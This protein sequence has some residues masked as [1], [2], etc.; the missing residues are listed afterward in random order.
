MSLSLSTNVTNGKAGDSIPVWLVEIDY[1]SPT[2]LTTLRYSTLATADFPTA[3][4]GN[5]FTA[6]NLKRGGIGEMRHSVNLLNGGNMADVGSL[7]L[8]L[9]NGGLVSDTIDTY[10]FYNR[11]VE[12][13]LIFADETS[14]TWANACSCFYGYAQAAYWDYDELIIVA[15]GGWKARHK[16]LVRRQMIKAEIPTLPDENEGKYYGLVWGDFFFGGSTGVNRRGIAYSGLSSS[17]YHHRDYIVGHTTR[18]IKDA[19]ASGAGTFGCIAL[20][21]HELKANYN[22]DDIERV[23]KWNSKK[24]CYVTVDINMLPVA[25]I[26][27]DNPDG[28]ENGGETY[29]GPFDRNILHMPV[30]TGYEWLYLIPDYDEIASSSSGISN[31]TYCTDE[32]PSNRTS[33]TANNTDFVL[34]TEP[35]ND[36][37]SWVIDSVKIYLERDGDETVDYTISGGGAASGTISTFGSTVSISLSGATPAGTPVKIALNTNQVGGAYG[38]VYVKHIHVAL[39]RPLLGTSESDLGA[40]IYQQ[41]QGRQF[42]SFIDVAN[43]SNSYSAGDLIQN[44]AYVAESVLCQELELTPAALAKSV[45]FDG[46]NDYLVVKHSEALEL[47]GDFTLIAWVYPDNFTNVSGLIRKTLS[48][49]STV[50]ANFDWYLAASTGLPALSLGNGSAATATNATNPPASTG[51]W[52]HLAVKVSGT[53]VTHYRNGA[54][55]GSATNSATRADLGGDLI[56]GKAAA[57]GSPYLNGRLDE[58]KIYNRALSDAE[59]LAD[60]NSGSGLRG[61]TGEDGLV[62]LWHFD[63]GVGLEFRDS[64]GHDNHGGNVTPYYP[65]WAAGKVESTQQIKESNFDTVGAERTSWKFGRQILSPINSRELLQSIS[66]EGGFGYWTRPDGLESLALI[67]ATGSPSAFTTADVLMN[68]KRSSLKVRRADISVVKTEF[69]LHYRRNAANGDYEKVL[70]VKNSQ[71]SEFDA[72]FTNLASDD[73]TYWQLCADAYGDFQQVARWEYNADW[74]RDDATAELFIKFM[75]RWL[76]RLPLIVQFETTIKHIG[77][78]LF[79]QYK[80]NHP[81][82]PAAENNTNHFIIVDQA[83]RPESNTMSLTLYDVGTP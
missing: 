18:R 40:E 19:V 46:S 73:S 43:H 6:N 82:L 39:R 75:I 68:G 37:D 57:S 38:N 49:S 79:D 76:T 45:D 61:K 74:I 59:V 54:T 32:D 30:S 62:G 66:Y 71:S 42:H 12:V 34:L 41:V 83:I 58:V 21:E 23:V 50:P 51:A 78:T 55:N 60:Y 14:P 7:T 1:G 77:A 67:V 81:L 64:S 36:E 5:A 29:T 15:K 24:K 8:R 20:A 69:I 53:T 31:P 52:V 27:Y 9:G 10:A 11:R 44:P 65:G 80:I 16:T 17:P 13:R 3:W 25:Y 4:S 63:E 72:K 26:G 48:L 33:L 22:S 35:I 28:T 70:Y 47:T 2:S 56:F